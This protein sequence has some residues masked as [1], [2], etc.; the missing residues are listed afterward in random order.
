M[1]QHNPIG[2]T[3]FNEK[4][5]FSRFRLC[6]LILSTIVDPL[7]LFFYYGLIG[8]LT[9]KCYVWRRLLLIAFNNNHRNRSIPFRIAYIV[10]NRYKSK[11]LYHERLRL[12]VVKIF[13]KKKILS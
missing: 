8:S 10:W 1:V 2:R 7:F 6:E 12:Q 4:L 11:I 13:E 3:G 9:R 5:K